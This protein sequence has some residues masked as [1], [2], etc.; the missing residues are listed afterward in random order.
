MDVVAATTVSGAG[1]LALIICAG[2]VCMFVVSGV[3]LALV[4]ARRGRKT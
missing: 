1:S 2:L 4:W 3:I